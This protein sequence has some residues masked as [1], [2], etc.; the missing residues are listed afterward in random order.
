MYIDFTID[1]FDNLSGFKP[2][3]FQL[4]ALYFE[5]QVS[6]NFILLISFDENSIISCFFVNCNC[7]KIFPMYWSCTLQKNLKQL[8]FAKVHSLSLVC[9][10][11]KM[12]TIKLRNIEILISFYWDVIFSVIHDRD[13]I[14]WIY[15]SYWIHYLIVLVVFTG[16]ILYIL[17]KDFF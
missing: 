16:R 8:V 12:I 2:T 3:L 9:Y 15:L 5:V 1:N 14:F 11:L 17:I 4:I 7:S 13:I 6:C 10:N